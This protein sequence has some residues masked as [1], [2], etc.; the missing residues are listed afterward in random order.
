MCINILRDINY[1]RVYNHIFSSYVG[2][3]T[4]KTYCVMLF[5]SSIKTA[6]T[7]YK[8]VNFSLGS[9]RT[10]NDKV[11]I[12]KVVRNVCNEGYKKISK[13]TMYVTKQTK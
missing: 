1:K 2:I 4:F 11:I 8:L 10:R 9:N 5:Y 6:P 7:C 13:V 3:E 12:V